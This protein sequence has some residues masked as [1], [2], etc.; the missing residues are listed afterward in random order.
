MSDQSNGPSPLVNLAMIII[1]ATFTVWGMWYVLRPAIMWAS[2][3]CSYY[4]FGA[5]QHLGWLMTDTEMQSIITARRLIPTLKPGDYG[6]LAL[7]HLWEQHGYVWRW[8]WVPLMLWVGWR[9]KNGVVRFKYRREIKDVYDLI[10]IQSKFFPASAI[11]KGKNL[12][13]TH[14]YVGPWATYALPLDFALDGQLLWTSRRRLEPDAQVNEQTMLPIPAFTPDQKQQPFPVKRKMLPHH[15]YVTFH[16]QRANELF[17]AQL[18]E[19]WRGPDALPPLIK[20]LYAV[21]VTQG[22]GKQK[23]AWEMVKQLAFS[24]KEGQYDKKG[25]LA[26]PHTANTAGIDNL[27]KQYGQHPKA[28]EIISCHA[29]TIN[30][31]TETLAWARSKGRLMHSNF[32]WLRPVNQTLWYALSGQGGQCPYWEAAG[33]DAHAKVEKLIG[34]RIM[35]P[36]TL[37]AVHSLRETLSREH[38]IDPGEYSEEHQR[39]LVAE[40]NAKLQ[41]E[42][43]RRESEK[44]APRG[45]GG[46]VF[47]AP[48]PRQQ[49]PA[50][51]ARK[52]TNEDDEP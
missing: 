34:K 24:F 17:K 48:P 22:A 45:G 43:D 50:P 42:K 40:A 47:G 35:T 1:I 15:R 41:A 23:E 33:P 8:L 51:A 49:P 32:L 9:A 7:M 31:L 11:I 20:A 16:I 21:F 28:L 26:T 10:E 36:L 44:R 12:L 4:L 30:V 13:D 18:G 52:R 37:S 27:L 19:H 2:F 3:F 14:P 25:A 39:K 29:H 6:F 38:W 5:Y 46:G